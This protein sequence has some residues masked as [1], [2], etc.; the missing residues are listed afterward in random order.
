[1]FS[2]LSSLKLGMRSGLKWWMMAQKARPSLKEEVRS[3]MSTSL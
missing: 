3:V 1:M 2:F